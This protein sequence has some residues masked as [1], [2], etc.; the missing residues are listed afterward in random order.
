MAQL[1]AKYM[2]SAFGITTQVVKFA[3]LDGYLGIAKIIY[4]ATVAFTTIS[5]LLD[6]LFVFKV[7][8]GYKNESQRR[9]L[10]IILL[11]SVRCVIVG[12]A[13]TVW[14]VFYTDQIP[15]TLDNVCVAILCFICAVLLGRDR[16]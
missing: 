2:N 8:S 10:Y 1:V 13:F 11:S 4:G 15:H 9:S 6:I 12:F 16:Y 3:D 5:F 14:F 7:I